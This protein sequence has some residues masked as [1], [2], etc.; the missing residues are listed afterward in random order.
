MRK[1]IT[2]GFWLLAFGLLQSC[3]QPEPTQEE[4]AGKAVKEYYDRLLAGD[5]EGFLSG[6][7][8]TD[9]LPQD[10]RQQLLKAYEMYQQELGQTHGGVADVTVSN[11][12]NDE[13]QQLMQAFL[14]LHFKDS[15]KEEIIVPMVQRNGAWKMR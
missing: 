14:L 15:V 7:V 11:V 12:R 9:S 2:F 6:K 13:A 8:D 5:Y 10:Y 1:F 4:L 3:S